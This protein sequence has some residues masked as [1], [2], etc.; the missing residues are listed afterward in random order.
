MSSADTCPCSCPP[1]ATPSATSRPALAPGLVVTLGDTAPVER[2]IDRALPLLRRIGPDVVMP[3][4]Y[5]DARTPSIAATLRRELPGVRLW[6]QAPANILAGGSAEVCERRVRAW[7]RAAVNVGAEVL[8][9]NGEGSS[10]GDPPRPGWKRGT[11]H[12]TDA[13][14]ALRARTVL[15]AASDEGR[16]AIALAW[17][18]HDRLASHAKD[19]LP[20]GTWFGPDS[21][22][23][24]NLS[25]EY[26]ATKGRVIR[27]PEAQSRHAGTARDTQGLAA[28]GVIR[29]ELASDGAGY[30]VYAQA[31]G[32]SLAA[33]CWFHDQGEISAS[34]T[35]PDT[36]DATGLL[37]LQVVA[38]LRRE[39]GHAPGRIGRYRAAHGLGQGDVD[40]D[41]L[42]LLGLK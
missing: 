25:Q 34:W 4:M 36:C 38:D 33:A 8:C 23:V 26:P 13:L 11:P 15:A 37:A 2:D 41:V 42:R 10:G 3:H 40:D 24:L 19:G 32:H 5:P 30:V 27:R 6:L 7:V 18:T 35:L 20:V 12:K 29:P 14:I 28:R 39:A 22:V 21:P 1:P 17:S 31:H 16:G 9:F